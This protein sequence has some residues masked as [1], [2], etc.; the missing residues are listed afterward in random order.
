MSLCYSK[1]PVT[2]L[3]DTGSK[4]QQ[5]QARWCHLITGTKPEYCLDPQIAC[6][7]LCPVNVFLSQSLPIASETLETRKHRPVSRLY[8]HSEVDNKPDSGRG[9]TTVTIATAAAEEILPDRRPVMQ[10]WISRI[11][12]MVQH[13]NAELKMGKKNLKCVAAQKPQP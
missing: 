12:R 1:S 7:P 10:V 4:P 11:V 5:S 13:E 3:D 8:L 9:A 2:S 6:T